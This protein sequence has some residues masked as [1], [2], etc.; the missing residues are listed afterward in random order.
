[1]KKL[2]TLFV[3]VGLTVLM[4]GALGGDYVWWNGR[5]DTYLTAGGVVDGLLDTSDVIQFPEDV[6]TITWY[7][8][9]DSGAADADADTLA[10]LLYG[11]NPYGTYTFLD[12]IGEGDYADAAVDSSEQPVI[13]RDTL[14][15]YHTATIDTATNPTPVRIFGDGWQDRFRNFRVIMACTD[16]TDLGTSIR[17][18]YTT[19]G[20]S[21]L[22]PY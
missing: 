20:T 10:Y 18:V 3:A 16:T 8:L 13:M 6:K 1:M 12:T 4:L 2:I 14:W 7:P 19:Y 11:I 21:L 15:H 17:Y 5:T 22:K 9:V